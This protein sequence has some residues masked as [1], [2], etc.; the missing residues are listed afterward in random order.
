MDIVTDYTQFCKTLIKRDKAVFGTLCEKITRI[1]EDI[2]LRILQEDTQKAVEKVF[3]DYSGILNLIDSDKAGLNSLARQTIHKLLT[4]IFDTINGEVSIEERT[5]LREKKKSQDLSKEKN[6]PLTP[7]KIIIADDQRS[8]RKRVKISLKGFSFKGHYLEIIEAE[9]GE[10]VLQILEKHSDIALILLD[11]FMEEEDTGFKVTHIIRNDLRNDLVRIILHTG[12]GKQPKEKIIQ[13]YGIDGYVQKGSSD[14]DFYKKELQA[15][16]TTSLRTYQLIRATQMAKESAVASDMAKTEFLQNIS[17][18]LRTPMHGILSFS[19][20]GIDKIDKVNKEKLLKYFTQIDTSA[21]RLMNLLDDLLDLG[22]LESGK[23]NY[24]FEK[25]KLSNYIQYAIQEMEELTAYKSIKIEFKK[26][27]FDDIIDFDSKK[28][29]QVFR[30][31]ISNA[32]KFSPEFSV[33]QMELKEEETALLFSISD[34]GIG[35]PEDEL[36]AVF[37]KFIQSSK[38]KTGSGGTGL[39]LA[40]SQQIVSGHNGHLWVENNKTDG[41]TF[42]LLIPRRHHKKKRIG[43]ILVERGHISRIQLSETLKLQD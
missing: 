13:E 43:E 32:I 19:K 10:A 11:I 18:E 39:G 28:L 35:I 25:D 16:L 34:Q 23:V 42:K 40:I 12:Q 27:A 30:N 22:Q 38:T 17:H 5:L 6:N 26:P 21:R 20:F 37:D 1:I 29:L 14:P 9:S 4:T 33:I 2:D 24:T 31:L 3:L 8:I 15:L 7:L 36:H 41:A